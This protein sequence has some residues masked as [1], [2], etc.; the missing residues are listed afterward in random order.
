MIFPSFGSISEDEKMLSGR[1]PDRLGMKYHNPEFSRIAWGQFMYRLWV[2]LEE[3]IAWW[4]TEC[5]ERA[6]RRPDRTG[7][8]GRAIF[9]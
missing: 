8:V 3:R 5:K 1:K 9:Q 7:E 4:L 6:A 2:P